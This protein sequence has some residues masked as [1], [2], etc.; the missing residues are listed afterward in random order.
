MNNMAF[1]MMVHLSLV[2]IQDIIYE[3]VTFCKFTT[4][5]PSVEYYFMCCTKLAHVFATES[6]IYSGWILYGVTL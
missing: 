1:L 5:K 4:I 2:E 3:C 6:L